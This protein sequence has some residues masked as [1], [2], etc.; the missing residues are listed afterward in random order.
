M[1]KFGSLNLYS[2]RPTLIA[3]AG[4]NHGCKMKQALKYVQLAKEAKVDAIKFQTYKAEKI[5]SKISP[6]Y[7]DL[8]QEKLKSQYKLFKKFDK[9]NFSDYQ[10]LFLECKKNNILFMTSL[11]DV[12]SVNIYDKFLK[13]YKISS[14]DIN[15]IPLLREIGKKNK[16]TIISSGAATIKEIKTAIRELSLPKKKI[17][18][19]H[20][21]LNYPT[22]YFD[23][24]LNYIKVLK[25]NFPGYLIG[26]SD[27]TYADTSLTVID[28][29]Y[30]LGAQIIEKHFSHNKKI[31]GNDH[32]HSADK[33]DFINF[34]KI[35]KIRKSVL[36]KFSKNLKKE[37]K[38]IKF[39]RRSIF[40]KQNI[41]K[42]KKLKVEDIITLRPG[43]GISASNWDI[44][45]KYRAKKF[46]PKHKKILWSDLT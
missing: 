23:A 27:H 14:S 22:K 15:N 46:I 1:K 36:G 40:A 44:V 34:Y 5:V 12:E 18:I 21:V 31:R 19:M 41:N 7:W 42:D 45:L 43:N 39:A 24:N 29:A 35:L 28:M 17:C 2:G 8:S 3:E 25:K 10:K 33:K 37:S 38:S 4:V 16:Y 11:F 9:F 26:Y 13:I 6:A 20:C 30:K 32:Y